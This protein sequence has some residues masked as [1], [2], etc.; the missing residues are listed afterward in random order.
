MPAGMTRPGRRGRRAV[1]EP[2]VHAEGEGE[3]D[4]RRHRGDGEQGAGDERRGVRG[5]TPRGSGE[6]GHCWTLL[7]RPNGLERLPDRC[8]TA[9]PHP[10]PKEAT[11]HRGTP[12]STASKSVR[13]SRRA[14]RGKARRR[15]RGG[16]IQQ[17]TFCEHVNVGSGYTRRVMTVSS[18][19]DLNVLLADTEAEILRVV[20]RPRPVHDRR[21]RDDPLPPGPGR[22]RGPARQADAARC[23]ASSPT[24]RSRAST[25]GRCPAR[26]PSSW[27]TTSASSTTTSRTA[28]SSAAT[29]RRCGRSTASPRRSTP[30]TSSSACRG[31]PSTG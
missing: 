19:L 9:G 27:A 7:G 1:A 21:V 18:D 26:R 28:T 15:S 4:D 14:G 22:R 24:P 31:S 5:G 20:A 12:H 13:R 10:R 8:A 11:A 17:A 25:P 3:E 16:S 30:A 6:L 2:D 23:W 29:G